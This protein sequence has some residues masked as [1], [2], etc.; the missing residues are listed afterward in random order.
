MNYCVNFTKQKI[1]CLKDFVFIR[2][3]PYYFYVVLFRRVSPKSQRRNRADI[4][5]FHGVTCSNSSKTLWLY[6]SPFWG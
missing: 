5:N 6:R 4:L 3:Y 2:S 1:H